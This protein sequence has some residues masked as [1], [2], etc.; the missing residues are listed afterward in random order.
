M[1][2]KQYIKIANYLNRCVQGECHDGLESPSSPKHVQFSRS[3]C[4]WS[5]LCSSSQTCE[6]PAIGAGQLA[7][8]SPCQKVFSSV[9]LCFTISFKELDCM[10]HIGC[11]LI[12]TECDRHDLDAVPIESQGERIQTNWMFDGF[13][14]LSCSVREAMRVLEGG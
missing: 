14:L 9:S 7:C 3:I 8:S 11:L 4:Q 10:V 6:W 1:H 2:E 12:T 5:R 13:A